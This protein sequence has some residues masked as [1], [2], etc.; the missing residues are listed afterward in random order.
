MDKR[1][2]IVIPR[3]SFTKRENNLYFKNDICA[4][5]KA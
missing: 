4:G 3:H 5:N 2:C 1:N